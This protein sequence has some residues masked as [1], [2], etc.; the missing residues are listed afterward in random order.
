MVETSAVAL[1]ALGVWWGAILLLD[2]AIAATVPYDRYETIALLYPDVFYP[3]LPGWILAH[4]QPFSAGVYVVSIGWT[5]ALSAVI[6]AASAGLASR[7]ELPPAPTAVA[8]VLALFVVLTVVE[9]AV[10]LVA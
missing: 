1:V 10:V 7:Y 9:A 3:A 4:A 2:G 8:L 6:G 5:I